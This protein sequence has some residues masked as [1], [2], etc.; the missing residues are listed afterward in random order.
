[1]LKVTKSL[2]KP[3]PHHITLAIWLT[4][5]NLIS[6][7]EVLFH[8]SLSLFFINLQFLFL[9]LVNKVKHKTLVFENFSELTNEIKKKKK[10]KKKEKGKKMMFALVVTCMVNIPF[11]NGLSTKKDKK[12]QQILQI[13][14]NLNHLDIKNWALFETLCSFMP[15]FLLCWVKC[16]LFTVYHGTRGCSSLK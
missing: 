10:E 7:L 5:A 4:S 6:L 1:M 8:L 14:P 11:K 16:S 15:E 2:Q 12:Q 3:S 13:I 9:F